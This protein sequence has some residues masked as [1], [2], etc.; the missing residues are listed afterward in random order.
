MALLLVGFGLNDSIMG[1]DDLQYGQLQFYD[2]MV[3]LNEDADSQ[4]EKELEDY[5]AGEGAIT[6][7]KKIYAKKINTD[8]GKKEYSPYLYVPENTEDL[9][10]FM[11][12][13]DRETHETYELTDEGA[14]VTE[15]HEAAFLCGK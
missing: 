13:R 6:G 15:C 12:F 1:I 5:L 11:I 14:I 8:H 10:Q 4:E 7:T 9:E 2:T 3:I